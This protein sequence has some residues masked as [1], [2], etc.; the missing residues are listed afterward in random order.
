VEEAEGIVVTKRLTVP[1]TP[2]KDPKSGDD[3]TERMAK[4]ETFLKGF[5]Q[6]SVFQL[7]IG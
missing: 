3:D 6:G 2:A 5:T 1:R 7:H 4:V